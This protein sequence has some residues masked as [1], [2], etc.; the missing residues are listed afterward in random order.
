MTV[1]IQLC[2]AQLGKDSSTSFPRMDSVSST[3]S[4]RKHGQFRRILDLD[5]REVEDLKTRASLSSHAKVDDVRYTQHIRRYLRRR[6]KETT[7]GFIRSSL[8]QAV[9]ALTGI[10]RIV[11]FP[12]SDLDSNVAS[13]GGNCTGA[14]GNNLADGLVPIGTCVCTLAFDIVAPL[15]IWLSGYEVDDE[16]SSVAVSGFYHTLSGLL[17]LGL[18]LAFSVRYVCCDGHRWRQVETE[19]LVTIP[20]RRSQPRSTLGSYLGHCPAHLDVRD[21]KISSV[22]WKRDGGKRERE[23]RLFLPA[24]QRFTS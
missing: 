14:G 18:A 24:A 11:L 6:A 20:L 17:V 3:S 4:M 22:S 15:L 10:A 23:N 12:R 9:L 8:F 1:S 5:N 19:I 13:G 16:I 2:V 7:L 21:E